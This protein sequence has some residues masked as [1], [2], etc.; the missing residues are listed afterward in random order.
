MRAPKAVTTQ[1]GAASADAAH[2]AL[3]LSV[4]GRGRRD[5]G[6]QT[7]TRVRYEIE[8]ESFETP[9]FAHAVL[10]SKWG[11]RVDR[12]CLLGTR[13]ST[14]G[15]L[16]LEFDAGAEALYDA[17]EAATEGTT[18][19]GVSDA[20]LAEL[21]AVL[22]A[23]WRRHV[24]CCAIAQR[25]V[26]DDSAPGI[27]SLIVQTLPTCEPNRDLLLDVT[28]G[29]RT[30]PLVVFVALQLADALHPGIA[31]R[32]RV[33][34]G[35][36]AGP[37]ARGVAFVQLQALARTGHALRRFDETLDG[38]DL[39]ME[40][41]DYAPRLARAVE[42]LSGVVLTNALRRLDEH[43]RAV[44]NALAEVPAEAPAWVLLA[45]QQ[46][47]DLVRDLGDTPG[48]AQ[49]LALGRMR[50][51]RGHY[52]LAILAFWEAV[53][54]V[55]SPQPVADMRT[56]KVAIRALKRRVSRPDAGALDRLEGLRNQIAHGASI[57]VGDAATSPEGIRVAAESAER[58]V[59]SLIDE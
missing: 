16:I 8:G 4:I 34:Y 58:L 51:L 12:V 35:E 21:G 56:L 52:G 24:E 40:L 25:E 15:A 57:I 3:L 28:H 31:A 22:S 50:R 20:Q 37:R 19:T 43:V 59:E 23:Q 5:D 33:L 10:Q 6:G 32:T 44:R 9:F 1:A 54:C 46:L 2:P 48:A 39:A 17:L 55:A 13:T 47:R 7:Y 14:W 11:E 18:A 27:A 36:L 26:D 41:D 30:V 45:A 38:R 29:W 53:C 42:Q 49:I